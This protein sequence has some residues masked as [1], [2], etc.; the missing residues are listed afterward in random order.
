MKYLNGPDNGFIGPQ[1]SPL[2]RLGE[3][4]NGSNPQICY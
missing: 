4:I 2:Q 3:N 1:I